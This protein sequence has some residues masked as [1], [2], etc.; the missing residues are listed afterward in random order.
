VEIQWIAIG[1]PDNVY[2]RTHSLM[3]KDC[4]FRVKP[5]YRQEVWYS[6]Q[7]HEL[8]SRKHSRW[9][10]NWAVILRI[11]AASP[12]QRKYTKHL[13]SAPYLYTERCA[14]QYICCT[15]YMLYS[16]YV[17]FICCAVHMLYSTSST[18]LNAISI[19]RSPIT[20]LFS[21]STYNGNVIMLLYICTYMQYCLFFLLCSVLTKLHVL[22]LY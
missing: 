4:T 16:M 22:F 3:M 18:Y 21:Y 17:Q 13:K 2:I 12:F 5:A 11:P 9:D 8:G 10:T 7:N 1:Q 15:E 20:V 14:V 6:T 19:V